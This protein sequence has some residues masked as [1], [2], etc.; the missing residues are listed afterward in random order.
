[1]ASL[2]PATIV[3]QLNEQALP[4]L[5]L[6]GAVLPGMRQRRRG[7]IIL[8]ASDA[9]RVT[10]PGES[11]IG[12]GMAAITRFATTLAM[13]AKRDGIRVNA[14]TSSLIADTQFYDRIM[15]DPFATKLFQRPEKAA[16]LGL[17][18]PEDIA[19]TLVSLASP[20]AAWLVMASCRDGAAEG[21]DDVCDDRRPGSLRACYH[22]DGL[23]P[24][25]QD[26]GLAGAR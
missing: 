4:A 5:L 21:R 2:D 12:A 23:D 24:G 9:A 16:S 6:S 7:A 26:H 11:V 17:T 20:A 8:V 18:R 25:A 3:A 1:M 14:V 22:A 10:T 13:E 19:P 15:E